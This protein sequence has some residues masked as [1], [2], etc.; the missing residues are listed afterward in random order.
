MRSQPEQHGPLYIPG[1]KEQELKLSSPSACPKRRE[2][3]GPPHCVG[4][5]I[6]ILQGNYCV[7]VFLWACSLFSLLVVV[8]VI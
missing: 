2:R 7:S 5:K 1:E 3:V 4:G 8:V 6:F